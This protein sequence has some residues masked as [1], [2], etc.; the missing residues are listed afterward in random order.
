M[1]EVTGSNP[2]LPTKNKPTQL[3]GFY[4]FSTYKKYNYLGCGVYYYEN[5]EWKDYFWVKATQNFSSED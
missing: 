4:Y 1:V 2:V 3:S 5:L